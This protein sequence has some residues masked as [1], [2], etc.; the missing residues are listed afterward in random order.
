MN[1]YR[2]DQLRITAHESAIINHC[3]VLVNAIVDAS[4]GA[5]DDIDVLPDLGVTDV[6]QMG[7][8]AAFAD[9]RLLNFNKITDAN[10]FP[11]FGIG[12]QV[13][14]RANLGATLDVAI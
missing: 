4:D 11:N 2:G 8:F 13:S 7:D 10:L 3:P 6:T 1:G 12:A 9:L 14:K 5:R